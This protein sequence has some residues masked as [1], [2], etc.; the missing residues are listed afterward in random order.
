MTG[1]EAVSVVMVMSK[2]HIL[3]LL[4]LQPS[5]VNA[6]CYPAKSNRSTKLP[7]SVISPVPVR[8]EAP[9]LRRQT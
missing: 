7:S 6:R 1:P 3:L 4:Y 5:L 8:D 2:L 9:T